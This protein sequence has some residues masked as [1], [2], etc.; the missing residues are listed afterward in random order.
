M[1][2][3]LDIKGVGEKTALKLNEIGI[4]NTT[5]AVFTLPSD[6]IDFQSPVSLKKTRIGDFCLFKAIVNSISDY[7]FKTKFFKIKVTNGGTTNDGTI[8][9]IY[10]FNQPYLK[11]KFEIGKEYIFY[12]KILPNEAYGRIM[13]NPEFENADNVKKLRGILP[14]YPL[15][16]KISQSAFR[17]IIKEI[18]KDFS[19]SSFTDNT[20][21]PVLLALRE[22]HFPESIESAN[23]AQRRIALESCVKEILSFKLLKEENNKPQQY[24]EKFKSAE[25]SFDLTE[26]QNKAIK[27]IVSDMKS[28]VPMNR[29]LIGD[30]GSGKTAVAFSAIKYCIESS[31]SAIMIAPTTLL[32]KQH[33]ENF[34]K[35]FSFKCAMICGD[36]KKDERESVVKKFKSG[37]ISVLFGTH[38]LLGDDIISERLSFAVIDEQQRF[39]VA[40]KNRLIC[41]NPYIDVLTMT[42]TP[43]PRTVY[44]TLNEELSVSLLSKRFENNVKTMIVFENKIEDMF[45]YIH[46]E[47]LKGRQAFIV[48]PKVYDVE[49]LEVFSVEKVVKKLFNKFSD[50]GFEVLFGQISAQRKT[51][52][53]NRFISKQSSVI[54]TTSVIEVGIDAPSA[55]IIAIL[56]ADNFGISAIHQLRGRV[57]RNGEAAECYLCTDNESSEDA[58]KRLKIIQN[59][60]DGFKLAEYDYKL[61]GGG[62][63]LGIRQSG[64]AKVK[65]AVKVDDV[66]LS[67]AKAAANDLLDKL[68]KKELLKLL[69]SNYIDDIK[70]VAK[71]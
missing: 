68:G 10:F 1:Q 30:V 4:N 66:L 16:G 34:K 44:M 22:V 64:R 3:L 6:Y 69:E 7:N 62:D 36:T 48:C 54:F 65:F 63:Y 27:E 17:N 40:Q 8:L 9:N 15:K 46:G 20:L 52:A 32:A 61:R 60:T 53:M 57:G 56:N 26:S 41:K 21:S 24:I 70:N 18:F 23:I 38:S 58:I 35:I 43:I 28:S 59:E 31:Y 47:C 42:A 25:F 14:L 55:S 11:E 51:E 5:D 29:I 12:G 67:E 49:G 2:N 71:I 33:Y 50:V 45:N 13:S 39:G 37:E 19:F